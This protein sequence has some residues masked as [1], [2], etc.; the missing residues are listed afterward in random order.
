MS[1]DNH[2]FLLKIALSVYLLDRCPFCLKVFDSLES[3]EHAVWCPSK[4]GRIAHA[5]C[6]DKCYD[7]NNPPE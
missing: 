1:D 7:P 3:L 2:E 6:F 5:H 4:H